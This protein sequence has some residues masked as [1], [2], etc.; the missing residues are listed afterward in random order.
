MQDISGLIFICYTKD[1]ILNVLR[2][3]KRRRTTTKTQDYRSSVENG[4]NRSEI[5]IGGIHARIRGHSGHSGRGRSKR[6][7]LKSSNLQQQGVSYLI[8]EF[9]L[10]SA[11]SDFFVGPVVNIHTRVML[12]SEDRQNAAE[13]F[14]GL[15][16]EFRWCTHVDAQSRC[17]CE[18]CTRSLHARSLQYR[19]LVP[20]AVNLA[21]AL[22]YSRVM[23]GQAPVRI[24]VKHAVSLLRS[25]ITVNKD[26]LRNR[27]FRRKTTL[28]F[29]YCPL[30]RRRHSAQ[31]IRNL[32]TVGVSV[33]KSSAAICGELYP[34]R[35][36]VRPRITFKNST[37]TEGFDDEC[38]KD[39]RYHASH[40]P[41]CLLSSAS[42]HILNF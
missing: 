29:I 40:S 15:L 32:K 19:H 23:K 28:P 11:L 35:P 39:Y 13:K 3:G 7:N 14:Y 2:G 31:S 30:Q 12:T 25:A 42:V 8:A 10:R 36:L 4:D 22:C 26:L 5:E 38:S 1:S 20:T 16:D 9:K 17:P 34:G 6:K 37:M 21:V 33:A 27:L 24:I 18:K 41:G